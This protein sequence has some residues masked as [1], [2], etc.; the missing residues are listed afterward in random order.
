MTEEFEELVRL[1]RQTQEKQIVLIA[2]PTLPSQ[3]LPALTPEK[4]QALDAYYAHQSNND[5]TLAAG[6]M[7]TW[8]GTMLLGDLAGEH[9][10]RD[11]EL[12]PPEREPEREEEE[13]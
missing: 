9:L 5:E 4:Q 1:A 13:E 10:R 11:T 12:A 8:M 2:D 3:P 7:G 6:L